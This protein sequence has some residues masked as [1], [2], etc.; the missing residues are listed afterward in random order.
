MDIAN[1]RN[2][3][4]CRSSPGTLDSGYTLISNS[5]I[6]VKYLTQKIPSVCRRGFFGP[7][8]FFLA[9]VVRKNPEI[10]TLNTL[11]L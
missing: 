9:K 11:R 7:G 2:F 4:D 1:S 5:E 10:H 8:D 6:I 3:K